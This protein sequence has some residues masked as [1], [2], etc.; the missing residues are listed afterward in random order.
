L[1]C[2]GADEIDPPQDRGEVASPAGDRDSIARTPGIRNQAAPALLSRSPR[3]LNEID[4]DDAN[5]Q[6][7]QATVPDSSSSAMAELN[8]DSCSKR[9]APGR[10]KRT[11]D[12]DRTCGLEAAFSSEPS[13][14]GTPRIAECPIPTYRRFRGAALA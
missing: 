9:A 2:V 1:S 5:S 7:S 14:D 13:G 3:R 11:F 6:L 8:T 12:Q 10:G 4:V